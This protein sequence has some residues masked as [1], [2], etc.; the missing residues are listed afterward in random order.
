MVIFEESLLS[1]DLILQAPV[2]ASRLRIAVAW[3]LCPQVTLTCSVVRLNVHPQNCVCK[4][5]P[6][7][8]FLVW[9]L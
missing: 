8:S 1:W 3:P 5:T 7:S 9:L 2:L 4:W 6:P